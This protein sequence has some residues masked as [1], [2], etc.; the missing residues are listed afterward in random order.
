MSKYIFIFLCFC[1]TSPTLFAQLAFSDQATAAGI[2]HE[3]IVPFYVGGG[4][5]FFDYNNDGYEDIYLTGG[6]NSDK[7]YRNNGDGSF[8][9]VSVAAG[10]VNATQNSITLGVTTGDLD[11]DGDREILVTTEET[12]G[13]ILFKNNGNGTFNNIANIAGLALAAYGSY[14]ASF[15]DYNEDGFLDIYIANYVDEI[16][17]HYDTLGE[18]NGFAHTCFPN[19]LYLNNGNLTFT[20]RAAIE[21]VADTGCTLSVSFT[22]YDS[23]GDVDI[24]SVNDFGED[25]IPNQMYQNN[26]G[27]FSNVSSSTSIDTPGIYG[28]GLA[29][30]D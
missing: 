7:L 23:D 19:Y 14:T 6:M 25:I 11:N 5:A 20:E 9:D 28:M 3:S 26:A 12:Y 24:F 30:G 29:I 13:L 27:T 4:V 21:A 2:S 1:V 17:F 15:G 16:D 10:I 18:I 22:D 8:T